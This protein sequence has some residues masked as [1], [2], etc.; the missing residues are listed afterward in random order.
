MEDYLASQPDRDRAKIEA[1]MVLLAEEGPRLRR[2]FADVVER[3]IRELRIGLGRL[4]HRILYYFVK[5]DAI[6]LLHS[7]LKKKQKLPRREL[8][9]ARSRMREVDRRIAAGEVLE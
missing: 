3:R 2:P 1:R 9:L 7:F 5:G 4:E 8:D 6:V